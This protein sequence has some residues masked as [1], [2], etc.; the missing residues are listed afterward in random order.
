MRGA[1]FFCN[2]EDPNALGDDFS[3]FPMTQHQWRA[4]VR[5]LPRCKL[6]CVLPPSSVDSTS[7]SGAFAVAKNENRDRFI[8]ERHRLNCCE[9]SMGLAQLPCCPRLRRMILDKSETVQISF[10]HTKDCFYLYEVPPPRVTKQ[11]IGFAFPEAGLNIWAT[12]MVMSLIRMKLKVGFLKISLRRVLPSN[13]SLNQITARLGRLQLP[14]ERSTQ[15]ARS[16]V[17]IADNRS[18]RVLCKN[19]PC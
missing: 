13:E 4:C 3:F 5:R 6:A 16:N 8:G 11:V 10:G 7:A 14:W 17:L 18:L 12:K 15:C 9:R 2:A 19:D 1:R